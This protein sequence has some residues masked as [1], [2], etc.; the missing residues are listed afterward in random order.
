[1]RRRKASIGSALRTARGD[2]D[3]RQYVQ[4][5]LQSK[6]VYIQRREATG[7][8]TVWVSRR[9]WLAFMERSIEWSAYEIL[10]AASTAETS[11][12]VSLT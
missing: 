3:V 7:L 10:T 1:M 11:A 12:S 8:A 6:F 2:E 9:D 4:A 5:R